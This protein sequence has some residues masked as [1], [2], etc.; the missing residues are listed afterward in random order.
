MNSFDQAEV[1][2]GGDSFDNPFD[3]MNDLSQIEAGEKADKLNFLEIQGE[4]DFE[5]PSDEQQIDQ[6]AEYVNVVED[7]PEDDAEVNPNDL[8]LGE[9]SLPSDVDI[10][11]VRNAS[12]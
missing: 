3:N 8:G 2:F 11:D 7:V 10:G 6:D 5:P 1:Q 4:D 12:D 9:L